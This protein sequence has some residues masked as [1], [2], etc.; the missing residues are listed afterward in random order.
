MPSFLSIVLFVWLLLGCGMRSWADTLT[1]EADPYMPYTGDSDKGETGFMIDIV[2][3]VFEAKGYTVSYQSSSWSGA[4][5]DIKEGRATAL[6]GLS[7]LDAPD[8]VFPKTEQGR[9]QGAFYVPFD[10]GWKYAGASS[11]EGVLL[12]IVDDYKY[13]PEVGGYIAKN[14]GNS[15]KI[16]AFVGGTSNLADLVAAV[17]DKKIGAFVEDRNVVS[18]F[19]KSSDKADKLI[20]AGKLSSTTDLYVAFA[21]SLL[22]SQELAAQL[23]EGLAAMRADGRLQTILDKY[24]L[25]DWA[26]GAH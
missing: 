20:E 24:G 2:K 19:L 5:H 7:K 23:S 4:L 10:S 1:F 13:N 9:A 6:V 12:G 21:P 16:R 14:R 8:L 18:Y 22:N 26:T 11:L 17:A 3:A 25:T 15:K